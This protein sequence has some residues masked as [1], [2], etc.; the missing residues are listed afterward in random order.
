MLTVLLFIL[1]GCT[2]CDAV[3]RRKPRR[4]KGTPGAEHAG[5]SG[6]HSEP[7]SPAA[8]RGQRAGQ[9]VKVAEP[10]SLGV[11]GERSVSLD[12]ALD[13]Q[14]KAVTAAFGGEG[15]VRIFQHYP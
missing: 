1:S 13:L 12:E 7:G 15:W 4:N 11:P 3:K 5:T 9:T 2:L 8:Q 10:G 6:A 14:A